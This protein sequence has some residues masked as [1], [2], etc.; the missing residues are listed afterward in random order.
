MPNFM[1]LRDFFVDLIW[2]DPYSS[3][4]DEDTSK[5]LIGQL[6]TLIKQSISIHTS[7]SHLHENF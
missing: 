1:K 2:N 5:F 4:K 7:N 6:A 3:S